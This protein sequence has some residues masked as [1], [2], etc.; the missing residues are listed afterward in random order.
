MTIEKH[1]INVDARM[2]WEKVCKLVGKKK[3]PINLN[4]QGSSSKLADKALVNL[5]NM[6]FA[7]LTNYFPQI[8]PGWPSYGYSDIL[9]TRE[10]SE[11]VVKT[12]LR[13]QTTRT[14]RQSKCLHMSL[15]S[16]QQTLTMQ[17]LRRCGNCGKTLPNTNTKWNWPCT[18]LD[19]I[20]LIV[21]TQFQKYI[22]W[23]KHWT[24]QKE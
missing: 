19:E 6:F 20:G 15:S 10:G 17:H 12:Q 24:Y 4:E 3:T 5:T 8:Q 21:L 11:S 16:H 18:N 9:P 14:S 2:R 13:V 22:N 7:D 23:I 1:N